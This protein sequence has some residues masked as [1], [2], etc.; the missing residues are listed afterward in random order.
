MSERVF[1]YGIVRP[2]FLFP[3][4]R[5]KNHRIGVEP[6]PFFYH[7]KEENILLEDKQ[8]VEGFEGNEAAAHACVHAH[9]MMTRH[10]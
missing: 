6:S 5:P 2:V 9:N 8:P 4:A 10:P 7:N 3:R 1:L